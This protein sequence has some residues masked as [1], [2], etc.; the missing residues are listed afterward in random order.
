ML[1]RIAGAVLG[2]V[3]LVAGGAKRA[4]RTWPASAAALGVPAWAIVALPWFEIALGA[5]LISGLV[6]PLAAFV[7]AAAI[8]A[9]SGLLVVRL[10]EGRRVPCACFGSHSRR[11]IG[12]LSLVR[13]AALLAL[14][15]VA[16]L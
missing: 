15:I 5:V 3:I 11:P 1:S 9:F 8:V 2:V 13:N 16:M 12:A 6:R 7:A 14:A 10:A 4:D